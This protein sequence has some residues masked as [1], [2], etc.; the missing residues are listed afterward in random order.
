MIRSK[1]TLSRA[2]RLLRE[3]RFQE[4]KEIFLTLNE[5][6][7]DF[8]PYQQGYALAC[9]KLGLASRSSKISR[10]V[11][12]LVDIFHPASQEIKVSSQRLF[13]VVTPVLNGDR[14]ISAT[15]ESILSQAGDFFIDYLIKDAGSS[16]QTLSILQ[17]VGRQIES[18][19]YPMR[20]SGIRFRV[21]SLPDRGLYDALAYAFGKD[22]WHSDLEIIQTYLNADDVMAIDAF[23]IVA[24][25][26]DNTP[27]LWVC[28]QTNVIDET[29][30]VI[31]TPQFPLTFARQDII[32]GLHDGRS[33]YTI[34]QEGTFWLQ[35]L[36]LTI[37]GIDRKYKLAGDYDLWRRFAHHTELLAL[38]KPLASFRSHQNQ[39]SK[40]IDQYLSEVD[41]SAM[42]DGAPD[43][44]PLTW[45]FFYMGA[46]APLKAPQQ[47]PGPVGFLDDNGKIKEIAYIKRGWA[48]W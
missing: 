45:P 41:S 6:N 12:L 15:L 35:K 34:Q 2:N 8:L 40:Q 1:I 13:F 43:A 18:G 11:G 25:V 19:R 29:G 26:F 3:G 47:K 17:K 23:K 44:P 42:E 27:A 24:H 7:P 21:E 9:E 10:H 48:C 46:K 4:A 39:L 20:C 31:V 32:A 38:D 5:Q 36:Y 33:L 16:D 28:G 30:K 22:T 14:F 37:G